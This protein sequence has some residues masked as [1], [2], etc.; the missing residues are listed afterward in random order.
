MHKYYRI[1]FKIMLRLYV[2]HLQPE[3][4]PT[5][6]NSILKNGDFRA[7]DAFQHAF[8]F[9]HKSGDGRPPHPPT[10]TAT[11]HRALD[12]PIRPYYNRAQ[13]GA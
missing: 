1:N 9:G 8:C 4:M 12:L 5:H 11:G 10:P 6:D 13:A 2:V 3:L 7:P